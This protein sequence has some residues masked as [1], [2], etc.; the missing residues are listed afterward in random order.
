[1]SLAKFNVFHWHLVDD[2]SFPLEL[3]SRPSI[4]QNGA[5]SADKVYTNEMISD[6]VE[7]ATG[8][9][10][11]VMPEFDNPG[12]ARSIGM[13]PDLT[14]MIRC[15]SKDWPYTLSGAYKM[16]GGPPTGVIDP[17]YAESYDVVE[18][19]LSDLNDLFPEP[20]VHLGGDEV[21]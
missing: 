19:I 20:M 2:D 15:F 16:K 1:M 10:V 6:I 5:F 17:Y 7:Y 11:K 14:Y 18:G 9:G 21:I 12:H 13:D 8:L 4:T 3:N